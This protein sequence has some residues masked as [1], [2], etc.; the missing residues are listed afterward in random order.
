MLAGAASAAVTGAI[1][2]P[3]LTAG[4]FKAGLGFGIEYFVNN[5]ISGKENKFDHQVQDSLHRNLFLGSYTT[6][7][8]EAG[9]PIEAKAIGYL[10]CGTRTFQIRLR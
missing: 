1:G 4:L 8:S 6:L 5:F 10:T 7:L 3:P 9:H 2:G